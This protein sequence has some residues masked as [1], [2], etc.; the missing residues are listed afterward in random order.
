MKHA[1][2]IIGLPSGAGGAAMTAAGAEAG[3]PLRARPGRFRNGCAGRPALCGRRPRGSLKSPAG[4][5]G[6]FTRPITSSGWPAAGKRAATAP[7][8]GGGQEMTAEAATAL[9]QCR[10]R[11]SVGNHV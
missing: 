9:T 8:A 6:L 3:G 4:S 1:D 5:R 2:S 11:A 10:Y 7:R